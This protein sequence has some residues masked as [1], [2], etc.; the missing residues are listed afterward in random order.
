MAKRYRWLLVAVIWATFPTLA[1]QD[2]PLAEAQREQERLRELL[3]PPELVMRHQRELALTSEQREYMMAQVREATQ[4][5]TEAQWDLHAQLEAL[6]NMI[7]EGTQPESELVRQLD[8]VLDLERAIKRA[9]FLLALRI[10]QHLTPEQL[11]KLEKLRPLASRRTG[12]PALPRR[13]ERP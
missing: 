9:R 3:F 10:R 13:S 11:A 5:F 7:R 6:T 2:E 4:T 12:G 8:R 1:A